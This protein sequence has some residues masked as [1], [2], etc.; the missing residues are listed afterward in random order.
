MIYRRFILLTALLNSSEFCIAFRIL[1]PMEN[2]VKNGQIM[3]KKDQNEFIDEK[4]GRTI[5]QK[6]LI[7][8]CFSQLWSVIFKYWS[9]IFRYS[10]EFAV[11]YIDNLPC[12]IAL[13]I[14]G[15]PKITIAREYKLYNRLLASLFPFLDMISR[16]WIFVRLLSL[17]PTLSLSFS[18]FIYITVKIIYKIFT[19]VIC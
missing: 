14:Y 8:F 4:E 16:K 15:W 6:I 11:R 18:F 1:T 5:S 13:L 19:L 10:T 2:G 17:S 7:L 12:S 9:I 3:W